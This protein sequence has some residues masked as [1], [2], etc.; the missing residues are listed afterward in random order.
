ML[1]GKTYPLKR[2]VWRSSS[3]VIDESHAL[4]FTLKPVDWFGR[5]YEVTLNEGA[6]MNGDVELLVYFSWFVRT[7][8]QDDAAASS[9]S[10]VS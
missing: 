2:A 1:A 5:K 10:V 9:V 4:L 6:Q 8:Y 3:E 7:V